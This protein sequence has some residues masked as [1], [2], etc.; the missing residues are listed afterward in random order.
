MADDTVPDG[1]VADMTA[2]D[3][4]DEESILANLRVRHAAQHAYTSTG[5]IV[6]AVNPYQHIAALYSDEL[7]AQYCAAA[8]R[9]EAKALPPHVFGVSARAFHALQRGGDQSV[10]V[11][12]E[13]GA[14]KTESVK[15]LMSF[16]AK[17]GGGGN[18]G[19]AGRNVSEGVRGNETVR[20][21]LESNPLMETFG[22]AK[23]VRNDNSSRFG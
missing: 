5:D 15:I 8:T 21:I 6:I 11:S 10:L 7:R 9:E 1:G 13:S 12:G 22:N 23:T 16:L 4:L 20:R 17:A 14:G 3:V 18:Q 19:V 2:L